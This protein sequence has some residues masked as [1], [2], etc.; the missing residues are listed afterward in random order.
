LFDVTS[1]KY[2]SG[3]IGFEAVV[4]YIYNSTGWFKL[5]IDNIKVTQNNVVAVSSSL[6]FEDDFED[7]NLNDWTTRHAYIQ[8]GSLG[9]G[10]FMTALHYYTN[11]TGYHSDFDNGS[12]A[13]TTGLNW[14]NYQYE[15]SLKI[16]T[17]RVLIAFY[18]PDTFL[19]GS[20]I[21]SLDLNPQ[22][23]KVFFPG[24]NYYFP[25]RNSTTYPL[26]YN[27]RYDIKITVFNGNMNAFIDGNLVAT[28]SGSYFTKGTVGILATSQYDGSDPDGLRCYLDNVK[29][30][31]LNSTNIPILSVNS[32]SANYLPGDS[33]TLT[34]AYLGLNSTNVVFKVDRPDGTAMATQSKIVP[35]GGSVD[36]SFFLPSNAQYGNYLVYA[37]TY[38]GQA[39]TSFEVIVS[40]LRIISM[41]VPDAQAN[42]SVDIAV[43]VTNGKA[44]TMNF[45]LAVQVIDA[46]GVPLSP[47]IAQTALVSGQTI[48]YTQ[49]IEVPTGSPTG[50]YMVQ[51]QIL[52]GLPSEGGYA[53]DFMNRVMVVY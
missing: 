32:D 9:S 38:D 6:L 27:I 16:V 46:N 43:T 11:Y 4:P 36:F 18:S 14:S 50:E 44:V 53:L 51:A 24:D 48:T 5:N 3:G 20:P 8:N 40:V 49:S 37:S 1:T 7:G 10:N 42:S 17:G 31:Q 21:Y 25:G 12:A 22:D 13:V 2:S 26:S 35:A 47:A 19:G 15:V 33:V 39:Q 45:I 23:D 52:T 41:N 29:V 34:A 30:T 28:A